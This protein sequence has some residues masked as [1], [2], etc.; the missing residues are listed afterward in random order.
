MYG[1]PAVYALYSPAQPLPG[2]YWGL[3]GYTGDILCARVAAGLCCCRPLLHKQY[4]TGRNAAQRW[5]HPTRKPSTVL[6]YGAADGA[7]IGGGTSL[8]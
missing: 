3:R 8:Y 5:F 1:G 4:T 7:I 6:V 2:I